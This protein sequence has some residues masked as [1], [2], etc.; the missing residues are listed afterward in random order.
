[1]KLSSV[2]RITAHAVIMFTFAYLIW[3]VLE[4][5]VDSPDCPI[6]GCLSQ[7]LSRFEFLTVSVFIGLLLSSFMEW[8]SRDR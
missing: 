8:Q 2:V 4:H 7:T 1:M 6:A 3:P 5:V